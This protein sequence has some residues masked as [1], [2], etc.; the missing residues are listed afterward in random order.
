MIFALNYN[1]LNDFISY[2]IRVHDFT[3][4]ILLLISD[5]GL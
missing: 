5:I 1:M 2:T 4:L 3:L